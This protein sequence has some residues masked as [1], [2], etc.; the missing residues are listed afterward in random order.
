VRTGTTALFVTHDHDEAFTVADRVAVMSAG[1]LLRVDVPARLWR[2]PGSRA[3]A[4]FLGYEA[5]VPLDGT[6]RVAGELRRALAG[7]WRG[8]S[9]PGHPGAVAALAEGALVVR[10]GHEVSRAPGGAPDGGSAR[11]GSVVGE[12]AAPDAR[13]VTGVVAQVTFR[14]GRSEVAVDV[15]GAGRVTA[16]AAGVSRAEPGE[17]VSLGVDADLVAILPG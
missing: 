3:V 9:D 2:E 5:F 6:S 13:D 4:E 11:R 16:V 14:R 10:S 12:A 15:E 7:T 17:R 1:R 8:G